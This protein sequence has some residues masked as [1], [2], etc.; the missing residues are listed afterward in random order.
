MEIKVFG[1]GCKKCEKLYHLVSEVVES[2]DIQGTITKV[3][4]FKEIV[5]AGVLKTPALMVDNKVLFTG[6]VP[7]KKELEQML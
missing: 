1:S 7:S 5:Q 2:R 3:E 4:D 6:R